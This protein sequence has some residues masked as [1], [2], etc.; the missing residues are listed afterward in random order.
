M[1]DN[2]IGK[3]LEE[4]TESPA[5]KVARREQELQIAKQQLE[6]IKGQNASLVEQA[7]LAEQIADLEHKKLEAIQAQAR[8]AEQVLASELEALKA[9]EKAGEYLHVSVEKKKEELRAA[10][11]AND[12]AQKGLD[13]AERKSA[14]D[15]QADRFAEGFIKRWTGLEDGPGDSFIGNMIH[16]PERTVGALGKNFKNLAA[17]LNITKNLTLKV[18]QATMALAYEQDQAVVNFRRATGASGEFDDNI[19]DLE[20]SL[21][22][23]GVNAGEAGQAVQALFLNV[24]DFTNMSEKQTETL[25]KTVAVLNELGVSAE[26]T[27]KNM[28]F[29][30]KVLGKSTDQAEHL[31]RELFTFAQDLGVSGDK[32][33]S[34]FASMGPQIAAL[35]SK[36]V[37]AFRKLEVQAKN[38]GL[39]LTEIL[40]IVEKFDKFDSAAESVGKL[41]ALLGGPYLNTLELV[42][43]TDPSKRFE[44]LKTRIDQAGLSFDDM[45]YYQRKAMASAVGLNEQQLALMMRGNLNLIKEPAKSAKDLEALAI[46][47]AQFNT[48][49]EELMQIG[50]A[51]IVFLGPLVGM[52]K[53]F[54]QAL[55]PL[56]PILEGLAYATLGALALAGYSAAASMGAMAFAMAAA[57]A[58][59]SALGLVAIGAVLYG[60]YQLAELLYPG[61]G[62]LVLGLTAATAALIYFGWAMNI[63]FAGIPVILGLL[64]TFG[65][66]LAVK[67]SSPGLIEL[68]GMAAAAFYLL[69]PAIIAFAGALLFLLPMLPALGILTLMIIGVANAMAPLA[70]SLAELAATS[71]VENLITVASAIREIGAAINEIEQD[72]AIVFT[73]AMAATA[74]AGPALAPLALAGV[75]LRAAAA[76]GGGA[77]AAAPGAAG[78]EGPAIHVHLSVDGIEFA[79]AVNRVEVEKYSGGTPKGSN[80]YNTIRDMIGQGF[81]KS[82][83]KP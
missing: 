81:V 11:E 9:R 52:F 7:K 74:I 4:S 41:N 46:Q 37:N 67:L 48:V 63:A 83:S 72:K 19:R 39:Q 42:A 55:E 47:T 20:R 66:Y 35:G 25:G 50:K 49:M 70:E 44:I 27:T 15:K 76:A 65:S 34:D 57:Y 43:E 8:Q 24:T 64:A 73:T 60:L 82:Q 23:A 61:S 17:P 16:D 31:T 79:T 38:T 21:F 2:E 68:L 36:G 29:A 5:E 26:T 54:L 45:D 10:K 58:I 1:A 77:P 33:A 59:A 75:G 3:E 12:L 22:T 18:A 71:V 14:L 69:P 51:M 78:G 56:L 28:Q 13:I 40:G 6:T 53:S 62:P 32:M 30:I 80:M